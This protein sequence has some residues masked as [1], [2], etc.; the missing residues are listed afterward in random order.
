[1]ANF[2]SNLLLFLAFIGRI[3]DIFKSSSVSD[4]L[5]QARIAQNT[6][7]MKWY[8]IGLGI[9]LYL[10]CHT[11]KRSTSNH[12][13]PDSTQSFVDPSLFSETS[14]IT[15]NVAIDPT[16]MP[17]R[18]EIKKT[19]RWRDNNGINTLILSGVYASTLLNKAEF[20]AYNYV[21]KNSRV[22]LLWQVKDEIMGDCDSDIYLA[23]NTLEV[24]D[25]NQDGIAE[26]VFMYILSDNCDATP[27]KTKLMMHSGEKELI[28]RGLTRVFLLPIPEVEAESKK[29]DPAFKTVDPLIKAY[30]SQKWDEYVRKETLAFQEAVGD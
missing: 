3:F 18:G 28:I 13:S 14:P 4:Y 8:V 17:Y 24:L 12:S 1:V 26:S 2:F 21:E 29:I 9:L 20:F 16:L 7:F 22:K 27:V 5:N 10:S 30:A 23:P 25:I 15:Y 19:A 6:H 11:D